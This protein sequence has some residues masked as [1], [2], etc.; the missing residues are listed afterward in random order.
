MNG[1]P[2]TQTQG[3]FVWLGDGGTEGVEKKNPKKGS[4]NGMNCPQDYPEKNQVAPIG[5]QSK[6]GSIGGWARSFSRG[7]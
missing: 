7:S 2:E 5:A 4:K 3:S 6:R 1:S